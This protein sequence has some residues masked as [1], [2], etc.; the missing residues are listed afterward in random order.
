M[1][2]LGPLCRARLLYS[3]GLAL[4]F[5]DTALVVEVSEFH[6]KASYF[7]LAAALIL[8]VVNGG[9][10]FQAR[11]KLLLKPLGRS[12]W[13]FMLVFALLSLA[14]VA[15]SPQ[16]KKSIGYAAWT[17]FD[18]VAFGVA[19]VAL[20]ANNRSDDPSWRTRLLNIWLIAIV[21]VSTV[22][23]ID[24][25]AYFF[26]FTTGLIGGFQPHVLGWT[27]GG[28]PRPRAFSY[29]PSFLALA[30]CMAQPVLLIRL[31]LPE[32]PFRVRLISGAGL[33]IITVCTVLIF[34]RTGLAM[35]A[36]ETALVFVWLF[37]RTSR[38]RLAGAGVALAT[39][40]G[41]SFFAIP[42]EQRTAI[43]QKFVIS[44]VN[45][46]DASAA[47][48][49]HVFLGGIE[50]A[51][52]NPWGSGP[53]TSMWRWQTYY[54]DPDQRMRHPQQ[55]T[56]MMSLWP[57]IVLEQ[58]VIGLL[59]FITFLVTLVRQLARNPEPDARALLISLAVIA[60]FDFFFLPTVTRA[61]LWSLF[62]LCG[63]FAAAQ[64]VAQAAAE[65]NGLTHVHVQAHS[66]YKG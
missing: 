59:L 66:T 12:P 50:L 11:I 27:Q 8:F 54:E 18:V 17:F 31:L 48:R 51:R 57:E 46:T 13:L 32:T 44:L 62:A 52:D 63:I 30:I 60:G 16:T 15:I 42:A 37:R 19:G 22:G 7:L 40:A 6:L 34:S 33:L 25:I 39:A 29:E 21:A 20:F 10:T 9:G 3:I 53:G 26:G 58:G 49:L 55:A 28:L 36:M 41:L 1:Q 45:K 61:D 5:W 24:F 2:L 64:P 35:F 65:R 38:L 43:H 56:S 14:L 23:I 47:G 4:V